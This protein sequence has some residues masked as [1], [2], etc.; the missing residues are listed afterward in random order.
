MWCSLCNVV[1]LHCIDRLGVLEF[2]NIA[3]FYFYVN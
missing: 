2:D 1:T 3:V